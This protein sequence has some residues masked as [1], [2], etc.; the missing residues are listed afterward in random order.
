MAL[1]FSGSFLNWPQK[2]VTMEKELNLEQAIKN[3]IEEN[4]KSEETENSEN[5][6]ENK[7]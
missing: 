2:G 6:K 4:L 5:E 7:N 1:L 3:T